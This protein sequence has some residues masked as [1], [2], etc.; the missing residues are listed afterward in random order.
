[1]S[2]VPLLEVHLLL[3]HYGKPSA[4][5]VNIDF[6]QMRVTQKS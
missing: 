2:S 4:N 3:F 6:P 1:M 5:K